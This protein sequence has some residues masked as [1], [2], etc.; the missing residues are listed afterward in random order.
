[1]LERGQFNDVCGKQRLFPSVQ[2]A[3]LHAQ[4]GLRLVSWHNIACG[5]IYLLVFLNTAGK[6]L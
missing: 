6:N 5:K 4:C 1:M 3:I 2:D